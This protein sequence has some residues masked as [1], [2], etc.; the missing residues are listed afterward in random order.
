MRALNWVVGAALL[1]GIC[2]AR[3]GLPLI[4]IDPNNYSTG[5]IITD[6]T[7]EGQFNALSAYLNPDPNAPFQQTYLLQTSPVYAGLTASGNCSGMYLGGPCAPSG[8]KLFGWSPVGT[9]GPWGDAANAVKCLSGD[10]D[11]SAAG[12]F[13]FPVLEIDFTRPTDFADAQIAFHND[14]DGGWIE[15]FN[16]A[17]ESL[18]SCDARPGEVFSAGSCGSYPDPSDPVWAQYSVTDSDRDISYVLIGGESNW[19]E[20]GQVQYSTPEPGS[21]GLLAFGVA[22]IGFL[23]LR[24]K[25]RPLR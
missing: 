16:S 6:P 20:V 9:A 7:G 15:A 22:A 13:A 2:V 21:L 8:D 23:G 5:Q 4:T 18:G 10:C 11:T 3:A 14:P 19:R 12:A 1:L 24:R 17:G 25:V